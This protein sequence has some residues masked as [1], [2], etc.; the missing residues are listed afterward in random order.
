[1][2]ELNAVVLAKFFYTADNLHDFYEVEFFMIGDVQFNCMEGVMMDA[3]K[4]LK[5]PSHISASR[6]LADGKI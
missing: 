5:D 1:M 4:N 3:N 6:Q 2:N